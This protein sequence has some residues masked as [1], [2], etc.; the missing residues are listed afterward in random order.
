MK[1]VGEIL[2]AA[3][4]EKKINFDQVVAET[5]IKREFLEAIEKNDFQKISSGVIARGFIKNYAE[6]L[7]IPSKTI[8]A[9]FRRDFREDEKGK[10]IPQSLVEPV[11][12]SKISWSPKLTL[13]AVV[14]VFF[15]GIASYLTYQ[16]LSLFRNPTLEVNS[17]EDKSQILTEKIEVTGRVSLDCLVTVNGNLALILSKG[18]FRYWLDLFPGENKIVIE[19]KSKKGKTTKVEKTVFRLDKQS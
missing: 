15:L 19:A 4:E 13:I 10:I 6:F 16:Y 2:R 5:K 9:I 11:S 8:L 14:V 7:N 12:T 3:R 18:E 17:P 1:T